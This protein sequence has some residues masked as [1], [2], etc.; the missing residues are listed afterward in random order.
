METKRDI[1][2]YKVTCP[3]FVEKSFGFQSR[4]S[5][6]QDMYGR[7]RTGSPPSPA[8]KRKGGKE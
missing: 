2:E 6:A 3:F 8:Q 7:R 4:P 5:L 1:L